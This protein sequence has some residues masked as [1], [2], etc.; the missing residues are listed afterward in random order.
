MA[1]MTER[2]I[3][4]L[5]RWVKELADGS[6]EAHGD[7]TERRIVVLFPQEM[8]SAING[9]IIKDI[10]SVADVELE[11]VEVTYSPMHCQLYVRV[12]FR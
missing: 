1:R 3:A 2:A 11:H 4:D 9:Q 12:R 8:H 10:A 5:Q 7:W 6:G